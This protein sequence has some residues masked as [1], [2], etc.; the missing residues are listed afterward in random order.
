MSQVLKSSFTQVKRYNGPGFVNTDIIIYFR[1][2]SVWREDQNLNPGHFF[3]KNLHWEKF[4]FLFNLD[5]GGYITLKILYKYG[6][7]TTK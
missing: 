6:F 5:L 1:S 4:I 7:F 2:G 3:V